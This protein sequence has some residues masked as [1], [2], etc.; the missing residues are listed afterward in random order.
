M[1]P[2]PN[3]SPIVAIS[4]KAGD[5]KSL[6]APVATPS[7]ALPKY[8]LPVNHSPKEGTMEKEYFS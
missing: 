7:N 5:I 4:P 3:I 2:E 6:E 1:F 8:M